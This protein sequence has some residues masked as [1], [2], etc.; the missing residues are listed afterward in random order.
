MAKKAKKASKSTISIIRSP[1][2]YVAD[3]AA[4]GGGGVE[5]HS[6]R[7]ASLFGPKEV[8]FDEFIKRWNHISEQVSTMVSGITARAFGEMHLEEIEVSLGVSGEGSIGIV[9]A[10]GEASVVLK[11]KKNA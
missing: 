9:T 8:D 11:F 3:M 10:K 2:G 5:L 7:L 6:R 4:A 1:R